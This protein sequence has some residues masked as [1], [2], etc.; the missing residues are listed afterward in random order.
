[1][2]TRREFLWLVAATAVLASCR[3][4]DPEKSSMT[5]STANLAPP[6]PPAVEPYRLDDHV[7]GGSIMATVANPDDPNGQPLEVHEWMTWLRV[8]SDEGVGVLVVT[9]R[10]GDL[11]GQPVGL[12]RRRLDAAQLAALQQGVESVPW[13]KLPPP[14]GGDVIADHYAIEYNR[15]DLLIQR[16]FNAHNFEF[17][18]A[19]SPYMNAVGEIM[20]SIGERPVALVQATV[21]IT[22]DGSDPNLRQL[23]LT[24]EN[25]GSG[26]VIMTDP[27]VPPSPGV[28]SPRMYLRVAPATD[29]WTEP[30]WT[31]LP[32]PTL[33]E[34]QPK[35]MLL[36]PGGR[37]D[38]AVPWRAPA[39]GTYYLQGAWIDYE[40]PVEPLADQLPLVPL[41]VDG[42][43]PPADGPYPVRGATFAMGVSFDVAPTGR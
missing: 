17:I 22:A 35:V 42:P 10:D 33:G 18:E 1:M 3:T 15:G 12:F 2:T 30:S 26:S 14:R 19:I 11:P 13:A 27:R 41:A 43:S 36:P 31:L 34:G 5:E 7:M 16:G 32:L 4:Q 37:L 39:P 6:P 9:R 8:R 25:P 28:A 29:G 21:T 40:G 24:L 23:A 38:F 20:K